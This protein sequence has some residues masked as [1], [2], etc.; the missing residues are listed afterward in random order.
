MK[1]LIEPFVRLVGR[2]SYRQKLLAT[3]LIFGL[4]LLAAVFLIVWNLQQ[5]ETA[6]RAERAALAV[7]LPALRLRAALHGLA[8][9]AMA[10]QAGAEELQD[11]LASQAH[12][13]AQAAHQLAASGAAVATLPDPEAR[14]HALQGAAGR[15]ESALAEAHARLAADLKDGIE[16]LNETSR[17]T[18]DAESGANALIDTLTRTLPLLID[19]TGL[20]AS[21]G[22]GAIARQRLK[23]AARKELALARGRFD[24]LV[25]WSLDNLGKAT[26]HHPSL[27]APLAELSARLNTACLGV[28]E[29]LTTKVL[30]TSDYAI[31]P[32]EFLARHIAALEETLGIAQETAQLIDGLLAQRAA[33]LALQRNLVLGVILLVL[34]TLV[35][36]FIG[37]YISIMRGLRGI[38]DATLAMAAGDLRARASIISRDE[39]GQVG[40]HFNRMGDTFSQLIRSTG[41]AARD[42]N[43]TAGAVRAGTEQIALASQRQSG[44]A[45]QAAAAVEELT[46]SIAEVAEHAAATATIARQAAA[47]AQNEEGRACSAIAEMETIVAHVNAAIADIHALEARSNDIGK[48]VQVIQELADQTNL[49]ALNAAI[50][51]ARA[52]EAGRGFSVVAD[53][54]RNLADRTRGATREIDAMVHAIQANIQTVVV[55]MGK[56]GAEV[57]HS[58]QTMRELAQALRELHGA[59]DRSALHVADI[60]AAVAEE[61]SASNSIARNVQEIAAMAEENHQAMH[62]SAA[63]TLQLAQLAA[64]LER[65]IADLRT[66]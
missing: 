11:I 51:A 55:G 45:E 24:P 32:A 7:Q 31:P 41:A 27:Q 49:L 44:A 48:I 14:W 16:A 64:T 43:A 47:A 60:V 19:N 8:A 28:Q 54:V 52:G 3:A 10:S 9:G 17:L 61:R 38:A 29:L 30:D 56:S 22:A 34:A 6:L 13:G 33:A 40:A 58:A 20:A 39:L 62:G 59:V 35:L 53:E 2:L 21:L 4:P 50:E 26:R 25:A 42:V 12:A 63:A 18:L 5:R 66:E 57:G 1:Q 36:G 65:S 37:A 46:V 15:D 23:P